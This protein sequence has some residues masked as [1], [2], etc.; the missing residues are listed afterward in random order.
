MMHKRS[1]ALFLALTAAVGV[2]GA[3]EAQ[4][5]WPLP[6]HDNVILSKFML[7]RLEARDTEA[8]TVTYW[9]G[10]AWI[11]SDINKLWLKTEGDVLDG[12]TEEADLEAYYSRAIAA[13][14]DLQ[15]GARHDF[16]TG[17]KP[18]RDWAGV[19]FK[20][21]APYRF[22]VDA[23]AYVGDE[24]RTAARLKAEY[25]LFLTQRW[26]LMPEVEANF[27][28]KP[29]PERGLGTGLSSLDL[30]LR[31][32]YEIRREFS[33]YVGVVWTGTYGG[34]A[35]YARQANESV[36]DTQYVVGI[37]SWW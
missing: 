12:K 32:R 27:Y 15:I 14:W 5:K 22:D 28:G 34:T 31:L 7:D 2:A 17:D 9:E 21:L 20:G 10:Q 23:T 30:G 35:E 3:Q 4:Q 18:A 25:E 29:D 8:G 13:F 26:V 16:K 1:I 11:G 37:R 24:E 19:G 36:Q 6:I 33:P